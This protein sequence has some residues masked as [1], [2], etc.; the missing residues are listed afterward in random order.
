VT[1]DRTNLAISDKAGDVWLLDRRNGATQWKIDQLTNRG[2][3][4]PAFYGDYIV[5][6]DKEGYLHWIN[7]SDGNFVARER[8]GKKGFVSAPLTVGTTTYVMTTKGDLAAFR[9]GAAL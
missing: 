9:A 6:G 5:V 4:R 2:L 8:L 7:T 1:V 3:T